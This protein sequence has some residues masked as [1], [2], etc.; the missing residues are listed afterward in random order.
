MG[1]FRC[2]GLAPAGLIGHAAGLTLHKIDI[3]PLDA[4]SLFRQAVAERGQVVDNRQTGCIG[5]GLQMRGERTIFHADI[6]LQRAEL[7][8]AESQTHFSVTLLSGGKSANDAA[9]Q[10]DGVDFDGGMARASIGGRC[11][12]L[13]GQARARL[14]IRD[15]S[16]AVCTIRLGRSGLIHHG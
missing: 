6:Q 13:S 4:N 9:D 14:R 1:R 7:R 11:E 5:L 3:E 10:T 2:I 16:C 15:S 8:R 12:R